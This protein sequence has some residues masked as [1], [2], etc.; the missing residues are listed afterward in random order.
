MRARALPSIVWLIPLVA[1]FVGLY[2]AYWAWTQTG[3]TIT[4]RFESAEG[5][6]AGRTVLKYKDVKVGQVEAVRPRRGSL[7]RR[8]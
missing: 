3:P 2:L 1:A 7:G 4:I 8:P 6:E 5:L